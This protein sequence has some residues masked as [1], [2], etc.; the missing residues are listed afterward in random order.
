LKIFVHSG[1][2]LESL[3]EA[4]LHVLLV[5][6]LFSPTGTRYRY[7]FDVDSPISCGKP[8]PDIKVSIVLGIAV[9]FIDFAVTVIVFVDFDTSMYSARRFMGSRIIESAAYCNQILLAE[10]QID[11]AQNTLIN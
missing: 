5:R 8:L 6:F 2:T 1:E 4:E 3:P 7:I 11:I 10:L 9:V